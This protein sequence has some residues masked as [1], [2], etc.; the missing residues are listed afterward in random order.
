MSSFFSELVTISEF[1]RKHIKSILS[2][3]L[4]V[5]A[6]SS[7]GQID[8]WEAIVR[9]GNEVKY[10][11][12]TA[13]PSASWTDASFDDSAWQTGTTGLGYGDGDDATLVPEGTVAIYVRQA[14]NIT[15]LSE[16]EDVRL[17]V[18]FDDG[19]LVY[20]N[21]QEVARQNVSGNPAGFNELASDQHEALIY[22]GQSPGQFEFNESILQEGENILAIEVHNATIGSS[23]LTIS[24]F[25]IAGLNVSD[26]RYSPT[27]S[28][29][30]PPLEFTSSNLPIILINSS[31]TIVDEPKVPAAIQIINNDEGVINNVSDNPNELDWFCGIE[32]RGESSQFFEKK[33]YGIEIWDAQGADIDTTFLGFPSEED[34]ILHG[35]YSDKSLLNNFL[36]MHIGREMGRYAS[37]TRFVEL[38]VNDDYKGVYMVMEKIKRDDVRVNISKLNPDEITGDDLTGGYIIRIDKGFYDGWESVYNIYQG[39]DRKIFFQYFYPDQDDIHPAQGAYIQ[40]IMDDFEQAVASSTYHNAAGMR[41]DDYIDLKSFV[42]TFILNELSKNVDAYRLSTY[43]NKQKDSKGGRIEAGPFWDFNLA[44]GNGDFCSADISSGWQYYDCIGNS[45]FWW[46]EFLQDPVFTNGLKCRWR[47][48]RDD[49]LSTSKMNHLIDSM[50]TILTDAQDRNFQ[51]W[52]NLGTYVWPNS[53]FYAQA[54]SHSE[55]VSLLKDWIQDRSEWMDANMPGEGFDCANAFPSYVLNAADSSG[56]AAVF[57]NPSNGTFQIKTKEQ[58]E[59]VVLYSMDGKVI[60]TTIDDSTVS[61]LKQPEAGVY[62]LLIRTQFRT[63]IRKHIIE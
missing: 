14:F 50:A 58:I 25:L 37:R 42:D 22:Q 4:L 47:E 5:L 21:G 2:T 63:L 43:F 32:I 11:I 20:L 28:W 33:S 48:L 7:F 62:I 61:V 15:S 1:M 57:P 54:T 9:D 26:I 41:Y 45:P 3:L 19:F 30:V 39:G 10:L 40:S 46:H 56:D 8:H 17:H 38:V 52:P 18:D 44:F 13:Q 49:L 27:P 55:I 35:P 24:P 53:W 51:R 23:D 12:P 29:F 6:S 16:L 31:S 36:A 59:S 60:Q 34:F